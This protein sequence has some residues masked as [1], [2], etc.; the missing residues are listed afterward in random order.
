M[1]VYT[2]NREVCTLLIIIIINNALCINSHRATLDY[3]AIQALV[4]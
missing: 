3:I 4:S 1:S 2:P